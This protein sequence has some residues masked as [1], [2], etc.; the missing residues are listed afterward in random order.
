MHVLL[1]DPV[2]SKGIKRRDIS[3]EI[4]QS[5]RGIRGPI[6]CYH[7]QKEITGKVH[8]LKLKPFCGYCYGFRSVL[9]AGMKDEME[10]RKR[11]LLREKI[12]EDREKRDKGGQ[13]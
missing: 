7:C 4:M 8:W 5:R 11:I 12:A 9:K 2:V 3:L 13:Q 10:D 6:H 1:L